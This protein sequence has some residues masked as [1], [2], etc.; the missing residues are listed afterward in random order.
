MSNEPESDEQA[1]EHKR[2]A[3]ALV[4]CGTAG[5]AHAITVSRHAT[6]DLV[7]CTDIDG[8]KARELAAGH[9]ARAVDTLDELV[10]AGPRVVVVAAGPAEQPGI[11][12]RLVELGFRGGVLCEKPLALSLAEARKT[13]R[14]AADHGVTLAVNHQRRFGAPFVRALELLRGGRVGDPVRIEAF[15]PKGTLLDWGPHW[16]DFAR[17]VVADDPVTWVD[18]LADF[19]EPQAHAGL[20]LEGHALITWEHAGGVRGVLETRSTPLGQPLLRIW[21]TSGAIEIGCVVSDGEGGWRPGPGLRVV[22]GSV[23][24]DADIE[25]PLAATQ[26]LRS[27]DELIRA[28]DEGRQPAHDAARATAALE[29][30]L[31]GY[32][33][34]LGGGRQR[35]PLD[36]AYTLREGVAA[37][38]PVAG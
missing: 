21:G 17:M 32:R 24:T 2:T 26:W 18:G 12:R 38:G 3:V 33:A 13:V 15:G 16:I 4:G 6:A 19:S 10:A 22:D 7:A 20:R 37:G 29:I 9:G 5:G 27:L 11:V 34:A 30:C 36:P 25:S 14:Y 31:A 23:E 1:S 28:L 35:L 8:A